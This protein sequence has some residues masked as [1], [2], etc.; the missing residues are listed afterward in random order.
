MCSIL[1]E[2]VFVFANLL[3]LMSTIKRIMS[4]SRFFKWESNH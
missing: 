3:N 2:C 1:F 4:K